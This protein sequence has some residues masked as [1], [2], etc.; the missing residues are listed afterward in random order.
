MSETGSASRLDNRAENSHQP[1]RRRERRATMSFPALP[2]ASIGIPAMKIRLLRSQV[3][4]TLVELVAIGLVNSDS[5]G[6]LRALLEHFPI[7]LNRRGFLNQHLS[8]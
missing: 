4:E 3:E 5:F 7:G 8:D 6:G 2:C 1:F